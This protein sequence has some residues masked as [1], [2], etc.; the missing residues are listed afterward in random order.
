MKK[1]SPR[2]IEHLV[3]LLALASAIT[4]LLIYALQEPER[5]IQAQAVQNLPIEKIVVWDGGSGGGLVGWALGSLLVAALGRWPALVKRLRPRG[6]C[7][8]HALR[9]KRRGRPRG[10]RH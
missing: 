9:E 1:I 7:R 4:G 3:G 8:A 2:I 10:H 6:L 5:I